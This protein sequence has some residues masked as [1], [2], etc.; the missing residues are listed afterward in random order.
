MRRRLC[1]LTFELLDLDM[2][3]K[4][5]GGSGRG[6]GQGGSHE[7]AVGTANYQGYQAVAMGASARITQ[8]IKVK[9]GGGY[10]SGGGATIGGGMSYQW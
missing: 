2:L 10:S 7:E 4:R 3:G 6:A 5:G 8:N 1:P 9:V